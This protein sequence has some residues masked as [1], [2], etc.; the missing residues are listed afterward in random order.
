MGL[1]VK[2][3]DGNNVKISNTDIIIDN[4]YLRLVY[5]AKANGEDVEV[6]LLP[7]QDKSKYTEGLVLNNIT[8][9]RVVEGKVVEQTLVD[10]HDLT[11][12][13]LEDLGFDVEID[14]D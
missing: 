7:Y 2:N 4:V 11:K 14:L 10:V 1:I 3:K 9:P 6:E 13:K 8:L 12:D 5:V